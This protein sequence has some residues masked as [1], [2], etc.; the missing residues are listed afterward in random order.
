MKSFESLRPTLVAVGLN[1]VVDGVCIE[2]HF[3]DGGDGSC[4]ADVA[5][6]AVVDIQRDSVSGHPLQEKLF[7][8]LVELFS[9]SIRN[10]YWKRIY[11]APCLN[12][13]NLKY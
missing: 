4:R 13:S 11:N 6:A 1:G 5:A 9:I 12:I 10:K 8:L 2:V 3:P 7:D